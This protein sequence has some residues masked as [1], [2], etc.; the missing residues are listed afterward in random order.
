MKIKRVEAHL[1][2]NVKGKEFELPHEHYTQ[3]RILPTEHAGWVRTIRVVR[4]TDEEES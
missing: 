1:T 4:E 3:G 2:K